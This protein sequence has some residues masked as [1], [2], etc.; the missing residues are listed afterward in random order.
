MSPADMKG[1]KARERNPAPGIVSSCQ[2]K[3]AEPGRAMVAHRLIWLKQR[4]RVANYIH[5]RTSRRYGCAGS[6]AAAG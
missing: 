2:P 5:D 1:R 6:I 3:D 4:E